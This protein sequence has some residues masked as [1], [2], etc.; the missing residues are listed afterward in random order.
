MSQV[1]VP[2]ITID[3]PS[4]SGKGT[5]AKLAAENL[6]WHLLDSG[7]LYRLTALACQ[8]HGVDTQ[9]ES[10]VERVAK[11][12]DVQFVP[13]EEETQVLLESEDVTKVIR[14]EE[15]GEIASVVAVYT[16]VREALLQRQRD[17]R[18]MPGLVAD[19][20]DMGTGI[21]PDADVKIFLTASVEE[22]ARRRYL[23]L[24][25]QGKDA[26]LAELVEAL[27]ARD[28]RDA[29][30][31]IAPLRPANGALVVDST[32]MS[33][34]QAVEIVLEEARKAGLLV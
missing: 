14:T 1:R 6:G 25:A 27:A 12:L 20:R 3:G 9:V 17:F 4:G 24:K 19:G 5:I 10:A 31:E 29:N 28:E 11:H 18:E 23:Q 22:R 33:I 15:V 34:T 8:R 30:R 26:S 2:V 7:A 21:F 16:A 32:H 13:N